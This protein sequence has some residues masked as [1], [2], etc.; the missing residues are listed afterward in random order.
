MPDGSER[1]AFRVVAPCSRRVL[2][3]HDGLDK[4]VATGAKR[5]YQDRQ[6]TGHHAH[7][8]Q[9]DVKIALSSS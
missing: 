5:A 8:A 7:A 1:D 6:I 4:I 3:G 9:G 2:F